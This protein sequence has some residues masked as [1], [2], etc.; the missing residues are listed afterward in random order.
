MVKT[1]R[2]PC[3]P[4]ARSMPADEQDDDTFNV[5]QQTQVTLQLSTKPQMIRL[6]RVCRIAVAS[7]SVCAIVHD[8]VSRHATPSSANCVIAVYQLYTHIGAKRNYAGG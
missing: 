8:P 7:L 4:S 2:C 3:R 6:T 1:L 5:L